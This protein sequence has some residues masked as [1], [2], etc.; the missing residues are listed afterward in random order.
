MSQSVYCS[1]AYKL[2]W[3]QEHSKGSDPSQIVIL[4]KS[5][6]LPDSVAPCEMVAMSSKGA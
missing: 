4:G 5:H 3:G 1:S 2:H 6:A